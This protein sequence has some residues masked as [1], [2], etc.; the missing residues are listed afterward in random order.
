MNDDDFNLIYGIVD[1]LWKNVLKVT[2]QKNGH[3]TD[4]IAHCNM[5]AVFR[6][7]KVYLLSH[8]EYVTL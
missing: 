2:S 1:E 5:A 8:I 3:G 7:F 4:F 6:L